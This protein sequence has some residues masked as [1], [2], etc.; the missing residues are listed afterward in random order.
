MS[1][2]HVLRLFLLLSS[3]LGVDGKDQDALGPQTDSAVSIKQADTW[4]I[5]PQNS[6]RGIEG[7]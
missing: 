1:N 3:A 4:C 7:S 6:L 5:L 2:I